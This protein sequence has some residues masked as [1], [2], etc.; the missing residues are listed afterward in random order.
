MKNWK[1]TLTGIFA[2][3]GIVVLQLVQTGTTDLKTLGI[4]FALAVLGAVSKDHNVS[5]V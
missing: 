5:G 4:A 2:G 1:T 3:A